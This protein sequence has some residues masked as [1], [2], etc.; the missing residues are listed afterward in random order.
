MGWRGGLSVAALA[1]VHLRLAHRQYGLAAELMC[2]TTVWRF[3]CSVS[4]VGSRE[5]SEI[6]KEDKNALFAGPVANWL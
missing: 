5:Y 3:V 2:K 4:L 6:E 1:G